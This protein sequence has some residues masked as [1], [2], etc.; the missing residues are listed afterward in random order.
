MFI[1]ISMFINVVRGEGGPHNLMDHQQMQF[2]YIS[3]HLLMLY[4]LISVEEH[5]Q[6]IEKYSKEILLRDILAYRFQL[7]TVKSV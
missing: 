3:A 4:L 5:I 2:P 7:Q 1:Y 6:T